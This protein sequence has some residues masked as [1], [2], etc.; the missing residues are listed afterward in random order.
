MLKKKRFPPSKGDVLWFDPNFETETFVLLS[1]LYLLQGE[2][3]VIIIPPPPVG[4]KFKDTNFMF[5]TGFLFS[6]SCHFSLQFFSVRVL[7]LL[8]PLPLV[9]VIDVHKNKIS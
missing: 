6:S 9:L 3:L 2:S 8:L 5:I 7:L 4:K 1:C